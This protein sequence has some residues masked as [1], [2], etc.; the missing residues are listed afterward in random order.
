MEDRYDAAPIGIIETG[1]DG[2]VA[3]ANRRARELLG[4]ALRERQIE[5][6]F[7]ESVENTVPAAFDLPTPESCEVEEYYPELDRWFEV[8]VVPSA[9]RVTI[10]LQDVTERHRA[11][12][13]TERLRGDIDRLTITNTLIS[14]ILGELVDASSRT[15]IAAT[16]CDRLG[17][18]DLYEFA[19]VGE[20]E[21]GGDEIQ[22]QASAGTPGRT[23]DAITE[24]L[25]GED[26]LPEQQTIETATPEIVQP[27]GGDRSV[28]EPVRRA[29]FADGLQ[30]LLAIPLTYGSNVY[31]VVGIYAADQ[32]A[33]SERERASFETVGE[34]AGF[35]INASRQRSLIRSDAVVELTIELTDGDA[36]LVSVATATDSRIV[37]DGI[38]GQGGDLYCY[39]VVE[40][41][42]PESVADHLTDHPEARE[43]R[44]IS[45]RETSGSL[46][47]DLTPET[48]LGTLAAQG[49][50]VAHA[51]FEDGRGECV[52][53]LSPETDVRRI[54]DAVTREYDGEVVAKHR[55]ERELTTPQEFRD[56]LSE[57]LTDKQETALR[58]AFF[59]DYFESPR[60]STAEEVADTLDITG[61][62]LL[63][64]LRAG[65]RKLLAEFFDTTDRT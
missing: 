62:T 38:V 54:A 18:T 1:T 35:A 56:E 44:V 7:P 28:P 5:E 31:G 26:P 14:D 47:V 59:A 55:R 16:I 17:E 32:E 45:E 37:L 51:E 64:H 23:L 2:V 29:A 40:D 3:A 57:R 60:G 36:P 43:A 30:S 41:A 8:S 13:R 46:E 21:L 15:E 12:Q 33:F 52:V 4:R 42:H 50:T 48:P 27:L 6:V 53:E 11:R 25:D 24:A 61:P 22:V 49:V 20:R 39:V 10:Y 65:Q 9:E 19:W 34:M 58:T 63:H